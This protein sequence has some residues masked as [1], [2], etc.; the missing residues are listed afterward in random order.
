MDLR[1]LFVQQQIVD[2]ERLGHRSHPSEGAASQARSP[3]AC[4]T[5]CAGSLPGIA[6][7]RCWSRFWFW[8]SFWFWFWF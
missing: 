6:L 3:R 8:F 1:D 5:E 7:Q 4:D 2:P